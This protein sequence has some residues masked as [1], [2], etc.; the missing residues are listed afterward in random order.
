MYLYASD[1]AALAGYTKWNI[2]KTFER[3][4][5]RNFE[6][7][8]TFLASLDSDTQSLVKECQVTARERLE[9][10]NISSSLDS[11]KDKKTEMKELVNALQVPSDVK[12]TLKKNVESH[13]NTSFGTSHEVYGIKGV[14]KLLGGKVKLDNS[15]FKR[16]IQ[17]TNITIV[18]RVDGFFIDPQ[19]ISRNCIVEIK[20]RMYKLFNSVYLYE[21]IQVQMY[22]WMI[23]EYDSAL[24]YERHG[25]KSSS[26]AIPRNETLT[27][28]V[29]E[30]IQAFSKWFD[31]FTSD[32]ELM[33]AYF[34]MDEDEKNLLIREQRVTK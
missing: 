34:K 4:L 9:T 25:D 1:I 11:P 7:Y 14:E 18:G 8:E 29:L 27:L 2:A 10:Y 22:M 21:E 17:G 31:T 23:Q 33:T 19:D 5:K 3:V 15:L 16:T 12:A 13:V 20:N 24:L 30:D 32:T 6:G 28:E 26:T